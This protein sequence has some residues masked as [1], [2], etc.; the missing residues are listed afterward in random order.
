MYKRQSLELACTTLNKNIEQL[1]SLVASLEDITF[2]LE[3]EL[4]KRGPNEIE[5]SSAPVSY[6][7]LL[8]AA[9]LLFMAGLNAGFYISADHNE[10]Q[11]QELIG[12][13]Q[14]QDFFDPAEV[15]D[16]IHYLSVSYTHLDVYKRQDSRWHIR[17][18][19]CTRTACLTI[20]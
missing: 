20:L 10:K 5:N 6:T 15:P 11:A 8:A 17:I 16:G 7:H 9:V 14:R 4:E 18:K 19:Y 13:I 12:K 3:E 2:S 1:K